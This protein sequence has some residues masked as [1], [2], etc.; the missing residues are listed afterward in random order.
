MKRSRSPSLSENCRRHGCLQRAL[1]RQRREEFAPHLAKVAGNQV[2]LAS[3]TVAELRY[4][5]LV[6][7][8]GEPRRIKLEQ[9]NLSDHRDPNQ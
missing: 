3:A 2:F 4:G 9:A 6:A 8:W 1:S 7:G 5:S